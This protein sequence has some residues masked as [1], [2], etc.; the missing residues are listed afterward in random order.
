MTVEAL[1]LCGNEMVRALYMHIPFCFHKCHYCD[2]Y[3][4]VDTRDR[5]DAFTVRLIDELATASG[6]LTTPLESVFVGGGT[7]TLLRVDLWRRLLD[8]FNEYVPRTVECEFT[9][10]ANPET[11]TPELASV[12]A[13]GEVH[14]V[15]LGAQSFNTTHLK[16]LERWHDPA[17]V[18]R[19]VELFRAAGIDNIN[20]DL[21]F[22]IPGQTLDD[23]L[24][25][26]DAALALEPVHVSCYGLMYEPNTPL[27]KKMQRGDIEPADE[28]REAAMYEATRDRLARAGFEHYEISNWAKPGRRCR[29][30][31]A[32]WR[33]EN[34]W[35]IGPSASGHVE[36]VRWKNA[37]RLGAYLNS[38]AW[39]G[40][41]DV[42]M[43]DDDGRIGETLMLGLRLLDGIENKRFDVLLSRGDRSDER[44][45]ALD[46]FIADG[47]LERGTMHTRLTEHGLMLADSVLS[48][49]I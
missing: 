36:G 6:R 19:S 17:S 30:N 14:R 43:L 44:R 47:L 27:T 28:D 3:S 41:T 18:A 13:A 5:Q 2:F 48:A 11:V 25:D 26:L 35:P 33:N 10:E 24:A 39:P 45:C 42:E 46:Q 29:H 32:Y 20:L 38:H 8:A 40:I 49:F 37:P 31:L 9:V 23:W 12:L 21:I 7:P 15:S 4:I 16:T 1:P 22:A 34:W